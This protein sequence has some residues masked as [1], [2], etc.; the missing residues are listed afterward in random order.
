MS[1]WEHMPDVKVAPYREYG[2]RDASGWVIVQRSGLELADGEPL[3]VW[4]LE[5]TGHPERKGIFATEAEAERA[6]Q[7]VVQ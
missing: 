7:T 4:P 3:Y 6:L 5:W 2:P 1:E